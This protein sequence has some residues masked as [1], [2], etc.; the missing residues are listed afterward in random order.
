M[1]E[2]SLLVAR[3]LAFLLLTLVGGCAQAFDP[4]DRS[5]AKGESP[6]GGDES[7]E[8]STFEYDSVK[9][10]LA[11]VL[12]DK[13]GV[14]ADIDAQVKRFVPGDKEKNV[15]I[16]IDIVT[17]EQFLERYVSGRS[18][19]E[20]TE[21]E[22]ESLRTR[23][24]DLFDRLAGYTLTS[25]ETVDG[26]RKIKIFLFCKKSLSHIPEGTLEDTDKIRRLIIHE[27]VHAKLYSMELLGVPRTGLP[28]QD[29]DDD[30][31]NDEE[32]GFFR[33]LERL[34]KLLRTNR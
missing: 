18:G 12:G 34:L 19:P 2:D 33:E 3:A 23:A 16:E 28:F 25:N 10:L 9:D 31:S 32:E 20:T 5:P 27:L 8:P 17:R 22:K 14:V 6:C 13:A 15:P 21:E 4:V 24:K 1:K 7:A 26:V 11:Q 30:R 29:H